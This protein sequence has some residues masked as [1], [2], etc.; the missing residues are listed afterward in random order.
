MPQRLILHIGLH[1]TATTYLQRHVWP[2]WKS[3]GYAGR[4][5][6]PGYTSSEEAVFSLTDRVI[7]MSNE[8]AG[9]SLK[10]SY[11][12][13]RTWGEFQLEKL[14]DLKLLYGDKYDL[15]V[16]IGLRHPQ[17]WALSIY[18]HYLKYGGVETFDSFLGLE[19][20]TPAT[21]PTDELC[22]MPKIRRI[23]EVLGVKAFCF[24]VEEIRNSPQALSLAM[25]EFAGVDEGPSFASG[26]TP[27]EGVNEAEAAICLKLNRALMNR[28]CLGKGWIRRNK[29]L[30]FAIAKKWDSLG[31]A[32]RDAG[33]LRASDMAKNYLEASLSDDLSA[34]LEF[35]A[36][37]REIQTA[38]LRLAL[39]LE[40]G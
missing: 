33:P 15:A 39:G 30:A 19:A 23:E 7:L 34:V 37:R 16:I 29:T 6:P 14:A 13:G 31:I 3:V 28:S 40:A 8:S 20:G 35:V 25:A 32:D 12:N 11:L 5:N 24:F 21:F 10:Q 27:N 4:P 26:S 38:D 1:K 22:I 17:S 36:S 18:K 9:G 2:M